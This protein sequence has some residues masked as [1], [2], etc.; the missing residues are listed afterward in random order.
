VH[1][2]ISGIERRGYAVDLFEPQYAHKHGTLPGAIG[3]AL[4]FRRIERELMQRAGSVRAVYIRAHFA[5]AATARWAKRQGIPVVQEVNG[6]YEDLFAAWPWTSY[7]KWFFVP[8]MREQYRAADALIT[9]TD[10][11]AEWLHEETGRTDITVVPNG[12]NI[13]LFTPDAPR[14]SGLPERYVV[15]FGAF[16]VWQGLDTLVA[17]TRDEEWPEDVVLVVAGDGSERH[18]VEAAAASSSRVR[19]LGTIPYR[20]VPGVV[21]GS[22][23][24]LSPQG[25]SHGRSATGLSPLKVYESLACG[26]PVVVTDFPGQA[27]L[28][29]RN[30]LGYVVPPDDPKSLARAVKL[31]ALDPARAREMG[32]RGRD[33]IVAGHSW[34]S[35]AATTAKVL[36][37]VLAR[38]T[39]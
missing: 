13:D 21:A 33:V 17:A 32:M 30:D 22:I 1:E 4:E 29:R 14:P 39:S 31:L 6:P 2:I 20:D 35:R 16:A 8:L 38:G 9:V 7:L 11:L 25:R 37:T 23:A 34:D 27:E 18:T 19:Y 15:F 28:V 26:V 12:A 5:A 36:D 24:G 3:R 10:A